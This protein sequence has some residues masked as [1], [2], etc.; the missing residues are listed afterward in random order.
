MSDNQG[1]HRRDCRP[2]DQPHWRTASL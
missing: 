2:S 1:K